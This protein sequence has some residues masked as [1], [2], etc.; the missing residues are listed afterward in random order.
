MLQSVEGW[1]PMG[2]VQ[3]RNFDTPDEEV[4]LPNS[5][6]Q[7]VVLGEWE[8][9]RFVHQPGWS[10]TKD[11]KPLA[12]TATCQY[13]HQG[14]LIS[15]RLQITTDGGALRE[16]GQ[17]EAYDIQPGHDACVVG[18]QPVVTIEFRGFR[19]WGKPAGAGER[20]LA[21]LLFTDVVG[22]TATA[23]RLGDA[24]WKDLL[25]R[26][27]DRVRLELDRFR[28]YEIEA[29]GDGF[30][31]LFDGTARAVRCAAAICQVARK[32]NIEVRVGVHSG[33]VERHTHRVRGVAVH[34]TARIAALAGAGEVLLSASTVALLE[35]SGLSFSDAGEHELKGLDGTRKLYRLSGD[36]PL[37]Q[38]EEEA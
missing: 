10:W 37:S 5:R 38:D 35:G 13:H 12:G 16:I 28:G 20:V 31:A 9:A 19:G 17:G 15:G 8:V 22:S 7:I 1:D 11:V 26:H 14:V 23:A 3:S 6:G 27:Y 36:H 25:S 18:H 21:T 34:V 32:D 30:L 33:E 29:I 24:A 4:S 2:Q